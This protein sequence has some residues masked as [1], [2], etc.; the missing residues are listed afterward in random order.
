[1]ELNTLTRT[2]RYGG[3]GVFCRYGIDTHLV[4]DKIFK[5][6]KK[7]SA[8]RK[9]YTAVCDICRKFGR[10][11]L[12]NFLD[13]IE[14]VVARILKCIEAGEKAGIEHPQREPVQRTNFIR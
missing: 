4:G 14:Y 10:S 9:H 3:H 2:D 8:A 6:V 5:T 13:G 11:L 1:M 7:T 12:Q